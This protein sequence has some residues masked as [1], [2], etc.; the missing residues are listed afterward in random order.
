MGTYYIDIFYTFEIH[1]INKNLLEQTFFKILQSS[2]HL[3]VPTKTIKSIFWISHIS[4][5]IF[6]KY[7][8][9]EFFSFQAPTIIVIINSLFRISFSWNNSFA[10]YRTLQFLYTFRQSIV[11]LGFFTFSLLQNSSVF[12]TLL[13]TCDYCNN[14]HSLLDFTHLNKS[15]S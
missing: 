4:I 3:W 9:T 1:L 2:R 5:K 14:Q 13:S 8:F 12:F 6:L 11:C 10:V 15:S 7:S